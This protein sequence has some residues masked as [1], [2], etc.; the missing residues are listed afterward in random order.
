MTP[1]APPRGWGNLTES[2]RKLVPLVVDGLTNRA[3]ADR[4]YVS[5]HTVNT[6]MKH[7]FTKLG[8]NTRV[9]LTRLALERGGITDGADRTLTPPRHGAAAG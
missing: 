8:I 9:E 2:E 1:P 5:I 3:I 6:H 7:I 4:L